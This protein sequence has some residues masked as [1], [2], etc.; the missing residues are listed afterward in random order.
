MARHKQHWIRHVCSMLLALSLCGAASAATNHDDVLDPVRAALRLKN[1]PQA[2]ALLQQQA[3]AGNA[4]AQYLLGTLYRSGM[5]VTVDASTARMWIDKAAQQGHADAAYALAAMHAADTPVDAASIQHW[6]QVAAQ[7]GHPLAAKALTAGIQPQRFQPEKILNDTETRKLAFWLAVQ[8]DDIDLVNLLNEPSLAAASDSFGRTALAQAARFGA[9]RVTQTLTKAAASL[10]QPDK[11]GITPLMLASGAGHVEVVSQLL[12]AGAHVDA[13]DS[14][15]NTALMYA[16]GNQHNEIAKL[17]LS[18]SG[19]IHLTNAQGWSVLDWAIKSDDATLANELRAA[20]LTSQRKATVTNSLP[21][22]PL[23]HAKSGNDLYQSWPDVLIAASRSKPELFLNVVKTGSSAEKP[24]PNGETAL[25]VAVQAGNTAVIEKLLT[26]GA[27]I[28]AQASE[29][30]VSWALRHKQAATVQ[31][32]LSKGIKPDIHGKSEDVPL[33]DAIRQGDEAMTLALLNA[34]ANAESRDRS[35]RTALMLAASLNRREILAAL[36]RSGASTDATD[37]A[38][39]TALW[40]AASVGAEDCLR[41]LIQAKASPD[42]R[43][44]NSSAPLMAAIING[45]ANAVEILIAAGASVQNTLDGTTALMLAASQGNDG[46]AHRLLAGGAKLD[47]QN[48]F[49]DTALMFAARAGQIAVARSLLT[50]GAST[51]LRNSDRA[52]AMDIA[53]NL[54]HNELAALL[55]KGG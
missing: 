55:D 46:I 42:K 31:L 44:G 17:L 30:P 10:N 36:L 19:N 43:D 39:H 6:L 15:G 26:N 33:L 14:V 50:A 4:Q 37:R 22:I 23:Q 27:T 51:Q 40:H 20:G 12:A 45:Q 24:G 28:N 41:Q 49:G 9:T 47:V 2:A 21:S 13:Q 52:S 54:G 3:T 29:T 48:A 1:F 53:K 16:A 35:G 11:F 34:A 5:G 8:Q 25:M 32:L 18:R 38:G 7:A